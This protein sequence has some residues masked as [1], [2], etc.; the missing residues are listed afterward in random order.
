MRC[1]LKRTWKTW[2]RLRK[3]LE[4]EEVSPRVADI[5]YQ[6]IVAS[7]LLYGSKIWV[8]P[9]SGMKVLEGFHVETARRLTGLKPKKEGGNGHIPTLLMYWRRRAYGPLRIASRRGGRTSPKPLKVARSL[10]SVGGQRGGMAH[11]HV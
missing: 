5:F 2:G 3:V 1:D 11:P 4:K 6:R 8:L 9:P 10:R 7:I